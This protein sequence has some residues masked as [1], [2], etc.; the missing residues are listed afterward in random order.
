MLLKDT[1][2]LYYVCFMEKLLKILHKNNMKW[3]IEHY[4]I[5]GMVI[6]EG[7]KIYSTLSTREAYLI[8]LGR[9]VTIASSANLVTH[10]NSVSKIFENASDLVGEICIGDNCFIGAYSTILP[11]VTIG[12]N[13]ICILRR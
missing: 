9:N 4:R 3:K 8:K 11:G 6:G 10:D 7:T 2:K 13:T 5:R 12:R 1:I